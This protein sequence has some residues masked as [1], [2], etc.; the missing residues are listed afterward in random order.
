[1]ATVVIINPDQPETFVRILGKLENLNG[2]LKQIGALMVAESQRSF[3]IQ[4][5]GVFR[6]PERYPGQPDPHVNIAGVISDLNRGAGV[7]SRRTGSR[8][9]ALKDTGV[10]S[11]SI[12]D[13]IASK[14]T[15]EVGTIVEYAAV[16]LHGG[17][18]RQPTP[19]STKKGIRKWLAKKGNDVFAP[20]FRKVLLPNSTSWDTEVEKRTFL[21]VTKRLEN[22]IRK[23]VEAGIGEPS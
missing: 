16:H 1:M 23:L 22:N 2:T 7:K 15:V 12:K 11:N 13:R 3:L 4:R 18:S 19:E 5:F 21:G 8:R 10:L 14:D 20:K 17:V 6:W 9:P